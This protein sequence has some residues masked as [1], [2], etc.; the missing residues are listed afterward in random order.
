MSAFRD[1]H[2]QS[3]ISA[4]GL[5]PTSESLRHCFSVK[6]NCI[7]WVHY[8]Q[9]TEKR[10]WNQLY[11]T[12]YML[13][14]R[15][16]WLILTPQQFSQRYDL[17]KELRPFFEVMLEG[18]PPPMTVISKLENAQRK[19]VVKAEDSQVDTFAMAIVVVSISR[20]SLKW[21]YS[22]SSYSRNLEILPV[23]ISLFLVISGGMVPEIGTFNRML[24][25]SLFCHWHYAH[26]KHLFICR[27]V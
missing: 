26:L 9:I 14:S 4:L 12:S 6:Q 27:P 22:S 13:Q 10:Y 17:I 3:S 1:K 8:G 15:G 5:P 18:F 19:I 24:P 20:R 23:V 7:G 2:L 16:W 11:W 25:Y 21:L